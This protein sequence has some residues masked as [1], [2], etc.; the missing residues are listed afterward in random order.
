[1]DRKCLFFLVGVLLALPVVAANFTP[2]YTVLRSV[3]VYD[4]KPGGG[5]TEDVTED[6]RVNTQGGVDDLSQYPIQFSSSLQSVEVLSA[7]TVS[8]AG[9]KIPVGKDGILLQQSS[10]SAD[11]PMFDDSKVLNVIFPALS[12]GAQIHVHFRRVAHEPLFPG[13]FSMQE[14]YSRNEARE[15]S[16]LYVHLPRGMKLDVETI[17]VQGGEIAPIRAGYRSW[18]WH[19]GRNVAEAPESDA[20]SE[21]DFSPRIAISTLS[22]Y[23]ELARDYA[24]RANPKAAVTPYLRQ[25]ANDITRGISDPRA[26]AEALYRW[27]SNNIRYVAIYFGVG[28]VVPHDAETVARALYGDCK[29]HVTLYQALLEAKNIKSSPVLINADQG[30]WLSRVAVPTGAFNHA[31]TYLPQWNLFVD[32]T[33]QFAPFGILPDTEAGKTALV[34]D[35]GKGSPQLMTLP[36]STPEQDQVKID[37]QLSLLPDGSIKGGSVIR[38][39]GVYDFMARAALSGVSPGTE[40]DAA[41]KMLANRGLQGSGTLMLGDMYDLTKSFGYQSALTLPEYV[42]LSG[43]TAVVLPTGGDTVVG[44][45]SFVSWGGA[46]PTRRTPTMLDNGYYQ[47]T[48]TLQ[49]PAGID[50]LALP[51]ATRTESPLGYY[52]SAYRRVGHAVE[53]RRELVLKD[54]APVLAPER[55]PLLNQ[56]VHA[57]ARDLRAQILLQPTRQP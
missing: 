27:V 17:D 3:A 32:T 52:E 49:L 13:V 12:A 31:I 40:S 19:V 1:M 45:A 2:S 55:Y 23:D 51:R 37:S 26:Q 44:L 21:V 54:N 10:E 22:G 5:Y 25:L 33:A 34:M 15:S 48:V 35:D 28:G 18:H 8:A 56:L 14:F 7:Y 24:A 6:L 42:D 29:D 43:P 57:V 20:I 11:A 30:W 47:E 9:K 36:I 16:D 41:G 38:L 39:K 4:V 53:V 50:V 46:Q